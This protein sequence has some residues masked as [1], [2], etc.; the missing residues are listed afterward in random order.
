MNENNYQ[1]NGVAPSQTQT[2]IDESVNPTGTALS[3][4]S[5][6]PPQISNS[7]KPK[8][9][10]KW[11][12]YLLF[13][14]ILVLSVGGV[15]Y[16]QSNEVKNKENQI[17]KIQEQSNALKSDLDA[18][19]ARLKLTQLTNQEELKNTDC[20]RKDFSNTIISS[21]TAE[22][23]A[24]HQAYIV[25]CLGDGEAAPSLQGPTNS[26]SGSVIVLKVNEDG[27]RTLVFGTG[28]GEPYCVSS[29]IIDS[30][31]ANQLSSATKL[32]ICSTY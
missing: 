14:F 9:S 15:Y 28:S 23:I 27:T 1:V 18:K 6:N 24:G 4:I 20:S 16:W 5:N 10:K 30:N 25:I 11:I 3:N 7:N 29:K 21:L 8:K 13:I 2:I 26:S 17:Q 31:V 32:P 19:N 12:I 22:P